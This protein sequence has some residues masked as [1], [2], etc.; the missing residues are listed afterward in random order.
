MELAREYNDRSWP[1]ILRS[2]MPGQPKFGDLDRTNNDDDNI[3][4]ATLTG[5]TKK[6]SNRGII[7]K[8]FLKRPK[9]INERDERGQRRCK[10]KTIKNGDAA[11]CK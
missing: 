11:S 9:T 4:L 6:D 8:T 5:T 10:I 3:S 7:D 2:T 1:A